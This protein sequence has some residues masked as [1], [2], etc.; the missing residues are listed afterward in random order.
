[1]TEVTLVCSF[2]RN[3]GNVGDSV[4]ADMTALG[5]RF[6]DISPGEVH[7]GAVFFDPPGVCGPVLRSAATR[8]R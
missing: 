2:S 6:T 7:G 3:T 5:Q 8:E 1:L 4:L